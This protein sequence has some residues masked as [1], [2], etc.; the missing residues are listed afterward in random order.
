MSNV[1]SRASL[2]SDAAE[3]RELATEIDDINRTLGCIRRQM[4]LS[5]SKRDRLLMAYLFEKRRADLP[6]DFYV[7]EGPAA[8]KILRTIRRKT[9]KIKLLKIRFEKFVERHIEKFARLENLKENLNQ[10]EQRREEFTYQAPE[11]QIRRS[12]LDLTIDFTFAY[13]CFAAIAVFVFGIFCSMIGKFFATT[14]TAI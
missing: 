1:S 12:L 7:E 8:I 14:N 13:Y 4:A 10:P 2:T 11:P 5:Q 9:L 3:C 6:E